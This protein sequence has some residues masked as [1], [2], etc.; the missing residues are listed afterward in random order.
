M[1]N[2]DVVALVPSRTANPPVARGPPRRLLRP[3]HAAAAPAAWAQQPPLEGAAQHV[4]VHH[5][6]TEAVGKVVVEG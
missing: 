6:P 1:T 3:Q 5:V 4:G 2:L